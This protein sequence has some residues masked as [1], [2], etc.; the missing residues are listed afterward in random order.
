MSYSGICHVARVGTD[1]TREIVASIISVKRISELGT[2]L[3]V[4]SS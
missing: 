4:S 3:A 2:T 1:V